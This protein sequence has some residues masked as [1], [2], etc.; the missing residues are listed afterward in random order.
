MK[1]L[2]HH[3]SS[4]V[5][6]FEVNLFVLKEMS[7]LALGCVTYKLP[8]LWMFRLKSQIPQITQTLEILRHMQKKKVCI[9]FLKLM[10]K[11]PQ[12]TNCNLVAVTLEMCQSVEAR[13]I[14]NV[15]SLSLKFRMF[16]M[17]RFIC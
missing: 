3:L 5:I 16:K 6:K 8:S 15:I 7:G 17:K 2:A 4:E 14:Q 12:D 11:M 1:K 9:L 13:Y 10:S